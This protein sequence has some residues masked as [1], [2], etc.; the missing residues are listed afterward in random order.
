MCARRGSKEPDVEGTLGAGVPVPCDACCCQL[1]QQP[2]FLSCVLAV[3]RFYFLL[4]INCWGQTG[5]LLAHPY[6]QGPKDRGPRAPGPCPAMRPS[7]T[8]TRNP[9][10]PTFF[11]ALR[12]VSC[13]RRTLTPRLLPLRPRQ[14]QVCAKHCSRNRMYRACVACER[15]EIRVQS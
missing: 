11:F 4:G 3:C 2:I 12:L 7:G 5:A 15:R 8:S 6:T 1:L 13:Q 10:F 14:A 9:L